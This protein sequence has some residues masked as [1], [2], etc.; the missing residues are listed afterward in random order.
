MKA[1]AEHVYRLHAQLGVHKRHVQ[2]S[3]DVIAQALSRSR[4]PYVACSFGK[5]SLCMLHLVVEQCP[6]VDVLWVRADEFDEW[7]DTERVAREFASRW[8]I[9]L[10]ELWSMSIT[11][12]YRQVGGFY[13]FTETEPQRRADR[14]YS[15]AFVRMIQDKATALACD[16]AFIGLRI[17]ESNRRR[18][19]L[20]SRGNL[21]FAKTAGIVECF[22]LSAWTA[23]DVWA[24]IVV[25]G[26]PYPNLYDLHPDRERARNGA[27][28]AATVP[29][30]GGIPTYF[31]QLAVLKR[32]Y[33]E[34]F[35]RFAA[36]FPEVRA[37]V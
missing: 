30:L 33:P 17:E 4:R 9:H 2:G 21:F 24:Y 14:A 12:C 36:E 26:I 37:Y 10:H 13:V 25:H 19:L 8:P 31:G 18:T 1:N 27:M 34:I 7:P 3:R 23:A 22:P 29:T 20:I 6:N 11:E 15:N 16:L 35:N 5:D 28:F 32:M